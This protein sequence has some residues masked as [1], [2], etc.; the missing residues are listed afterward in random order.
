MH[1]PHL[2]KDK[3]P[4]NDPISLRVLDTPQSNHNAE[5]C[6]TSNS[7][8]SL[9]KLME[10]IKLLLQ[11]LEDKIKNLTK[12]PDP[13]VRKAICSVKYTL[14]ATLAFTHGV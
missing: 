3:K 6:Q 10:E 14:T 7:Q 13:I 12:E 11:E 8:D 9:Q 2:C 4:S 1:F 5:V